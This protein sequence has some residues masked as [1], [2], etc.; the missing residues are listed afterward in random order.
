MSDDNQVQTTSPTITPSAQAVND[1]AALR[2]KVAQLVPGV[3]PEL[4]KADS[5]TALMQSIDESKAIFERYAAAKPAA[6]VTTTT[7]TATVPEA[8]PTPP[9]AVPGGGITF[10][11]DLNKLP[12]SELIKR[13]LAQKRAG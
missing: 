1:I 6:E 2:D 7:T 9:P 13:G 12:A 4:L 11:E 5:I 10:H 8:T 3:I